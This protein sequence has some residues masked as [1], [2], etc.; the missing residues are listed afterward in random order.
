MTCL[1]CRIVAGEIDSDIVYRDEI[2]TAFRDINPQA[3]VHILVV[4]ND[5]IPSVASIT[6]EQE[7]LA[8]HLLHVAGMLAEREGIA[9]SGFRLV[10]N[11]G[12][13]AGQSVDHLHVHLL[14]GRHLSWP[15]G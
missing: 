13:D 5:H 1:F 2:S 15:P 8:G 12:P 3:P 7:Q 10:V 9:T 4:P 6:P 11:T 14:G